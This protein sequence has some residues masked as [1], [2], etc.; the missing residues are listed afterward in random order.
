MDYSLPAWIGGLAGMIVAFVIY[1][2]AIRAIERTV[3]AKL[4]SET[5]Q[6]RAEFEGKLSVMRRV[7]LGFGIAV[8]AIIGYWIGNAIG[9]AGRFP[10]H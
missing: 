6:E 9:G 4:P 8:G 2:P 1:V 7:I 3:R 10:P 5:P